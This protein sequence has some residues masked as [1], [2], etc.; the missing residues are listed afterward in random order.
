LVGVYK[1]WPTGIDMNTLLIRG[2]EHV[3]PS[4]F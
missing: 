4:V 3:H 2:R 1:T